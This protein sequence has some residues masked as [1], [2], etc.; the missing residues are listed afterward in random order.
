MQEERAHVASK[1]SAVQN[2]QLGSPGDPPQYPIESVDN[3]LKLILLLGEEHELRLT[4][5]GAL[6]GVATSTAHR[7]LAMLAWR[8]FVRQNP[9]TKAYGPWPG[10]DDGG[11][12]GAAQ[13]GCP[14]TGA[15]DPRG[16][17]RRPSVR[18]ATWA[19][20]RATMS[21]SSPLPSPMWPCAVVSRL[22]KTLPA[23]CTST[24]KALLAEL[25]DEQLFR[26]YPDEQLEI[27][28][29]NSIRSRDELVAEL[30]RT[31]LDG[32]AVNRQE[33][34]DGV[35]SDRGPG[36][37]LVG[38]ATGDQRLRA[39]A[40]VTAGQGQVPSAVTAGRRDPPRR[41]VG[42]NRPGSS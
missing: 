6:L 9:V 1:L 23:H 15:A 5:A 17:Q 12:L 30:V 37:R 39:R 4:D 3:A 40:A 26:L 34:E 13:D 18:P 41:T 11:L 35:A 10:A 31:R 22:G 36:P 42:V 27:V 38:T 16:P 7:L 29:P 20:S 2:R 28:T 24:G 8:G 25:S 19:R 32:Y 21:D 33:S 14:E